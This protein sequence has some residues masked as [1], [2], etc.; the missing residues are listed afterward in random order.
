MAEQD[1]SSFARTCAA[2]GR[3]VPARISQCRCGAALAGGPGEAPDATSREG[4]RDRRN[5]VKAVLAFV[6]VIAAA[7]LGYMAAVTGRSEPQAQQSAT[8]ARP[9]TQAANASAPASGSPPASASAPAPAAPPPITEMPLPDLTPHS[10]PAPAPAGTAIEDVVN[11]AMGA[12]VLIETA[13]SRGSGFFVAPDT[14]LTNVHVVKNS[15]TVTLRRADG[16]TAQ[17]RVRDQAP[18]FDVAVLKVSTP[19]AQQ[20][21]IPL[22]AGQSVRVGQEVVAIGSALGVLQN[23]VTRGI[24]SGVRT[25]GSVTLVQT[26]A[27]LNPGNSGGPLLDRT[28]A[29]IGIATMGFRR[30]EGLNFAVGIDHARALLE[31]RAPGPPPAAKP[32][33]EELRDLMPA[34]KSDA[35]RRAAETLRAYEES[36]AALGRRADAFDRQWQ[37]FRDECYRSS[38]AGSFDREWFVLL[39]TGALP[40]GVAPRCANYFDDLKGN[41]ERFRS[42]IMSVE[43]TAR[44][45]GV[46]PGVGRDLRRKHR[47]TNEMW[48]R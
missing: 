26:D 5:T 35:E 1:P 2:C 14:V 7:L 31:G 9:T 39:K 3:R 22:G 24:V 42:D 11:R 20:P 44:Q 41:A 47:I 29:A 48:E 10:A 17:A 36:M 33:D 32:G 23:T 38:I 34:V 19:A 43:E 46:P 45:A 21:V 15:I 30:Q 16:S 37:R 25:A 28:G 40:G 6:F 8:P 18:A 27:A 12:V 13:D 4:T